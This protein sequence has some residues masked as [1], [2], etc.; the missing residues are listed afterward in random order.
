MKV[1]TGFVVVATV[2]LFFSLPVTAVASDQIPI[3]PRNEMSVDLA[4]PIAMSLAVT[5]GYSVSKHEATHLWCLGLAP[6][7]R[8][9]Q[10]KYQPLLEG[11][12][13]QLNP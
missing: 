2:V 8:R 7:Q 12:P 1:F 3:G 10:P 11:M 4:L 9:V 6:D 5:D 13:I